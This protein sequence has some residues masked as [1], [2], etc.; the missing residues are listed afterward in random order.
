MPSPPPPANFRS[1]SGA[2]AWAGA[3]ALTAS[4]GRSALSVDGSDEQLGVKRPHAFQRL[5]VSSLV[6]AVHVGA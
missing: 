6:G 5:L 4:D 2:G 1:F 3:S